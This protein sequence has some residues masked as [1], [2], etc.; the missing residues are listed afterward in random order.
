MAKNIECNSHKNRLSVH[1]YVHCA[2]KATVLLIPEPD[3]SLSP[4]QKPGSVQKHLF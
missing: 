2:L 1:L 4:P 3:D